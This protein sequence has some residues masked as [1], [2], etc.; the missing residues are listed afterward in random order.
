MWIVRLALRRPVHVRR[1]GAADP[2][3]GAARDR[4]ARRPTSSRTS[5]SRS[6][7]SSGTTAGSSAAGDGE[8]DRHRLRARADDDG[9]RHRAHRVAVAA[10]ASRVIKV[11]FQPGAN[12]EPAIAQVTAVSQTH[13]APAAARAPRRRS[14]SRYNASSVPI[15]QL[16]LSSQGLSEQQL[17]D[18]GVNFIRT[19]LATVPG[20]RDP[21]PV[22]RQAAADQVD[23]DPPALQ[24]HG[25]RAGRRRQRDQRAEPDPARRARRRSARA[26]T[27]SSSTAARETIDELNDLPIKTRRRRRRSTSATSP[28]CATASRRRPTSCASTASARRC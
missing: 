22:R 11:F 23:L 28:T 8:A 12:I 7:A 15:L 19:Q 16:A 10:T 18:L 3:L 24:A 13:A 2:V 14:S 27:T 26:N 17:F 5:T 6:S 1:A 20:R 4:R 25:P 9:Q 21:V